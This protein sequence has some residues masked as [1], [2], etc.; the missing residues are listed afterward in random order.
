[1]ITTLLRAFVL[2]LVFATPAAAE[3]AW[4]LWTSHLPEPTMKDPS[5]S[6]IWT[7]YKA[8]SQEDGGVRACRSEEYRMMEKRPSFTVYDCLPDTVDPRGPKGG[9]R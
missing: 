4:V 8:Y 5:P 9:G 6:T 3:C 2:L 7:R 1:V